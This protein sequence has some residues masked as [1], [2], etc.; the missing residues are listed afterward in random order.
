[1]VGE[2]GEWSQSN[3]T[4]T[5]VCIVF[6][7]LALLVLLGFDLVAEFAYDSE[8]ERQQSCDSKDALNA[9]IQQGNQTSAGL[10]ESDSWG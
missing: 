1:M 10:P 3:I 9:H 2:S 8:V 7:S 5:P 4:R 6:A